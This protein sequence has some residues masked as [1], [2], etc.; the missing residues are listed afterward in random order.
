MAVRANRWLVLFL[1]LAAC[2][3]IVL[4]ITILHVAVPSFTSALEP[5]RALTGKNHPRFADLGSF[6]RISPL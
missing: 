5:G 2:L 4:D 3:P 1:V 6:F